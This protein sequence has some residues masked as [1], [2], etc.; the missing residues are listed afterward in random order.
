MRFNDY[1][2]T[3]RKGYDLTQERLVQELYAF[4]DAFGGLDV[5]TLSRWES[6]QTQPPLSKQVLIV[7][8]FR[9]Y[10]SHP[11]PCL[12]IDARSENELCRIGVYN[13]MGKSKEHIF[14]FP[15]HAFGIDDITITHLRSHEQMQE[16]LKV[17][18]AIIDD[19][20]KGYYGITLD[21]LER[22][23]LHP[24]NL[25]IVAQSGAQ[26]LGMFN[27]LKL[28]P[29]SFKEL[30]S[31][32]KEVKQLSDDDFA[33]LNEASSVFLLP[34]YFY[35][36]TV[37]S[38]LLVRYYAHLIAH[39]DSIVEVGGTAAVEGGKKFAQKMHLE[40]FGDKTLPDRT[41]SAYSAPI[42]TI[43]INPDVL[44]MIFQKEQCPEE[45]G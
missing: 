4:D 35:N 45:N 40:Y 5:R 12:D 36:E 34:S 43:L 25:F 19:I 28:K 14:H 7:R 39:Q 16:T 38:L 37:A 13:L 6:A 11:F 17:S 23:S 30:I 24:A 2:K 31:F 22:W 21:D 44:R 27:L 15:E 20:T 29:T 41:V 32:E 8:F 26:T 18:H 1:L 9:R 33:A 3:C 42:E 10:S